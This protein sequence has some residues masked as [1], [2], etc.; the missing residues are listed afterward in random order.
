M[1]VADLF[2]PLLK[3]SQ[4]QYVVEALDTELRSIFNQHIEAPLS[5]AEQMIISTAA[6]KLRAWA[7]VRLQTATI[8]PQQGK[9]SVDSLKKIISNPQA[10]A[11]QLLHNAMIGSWT[12]KAW[13][14]GIPEVNTQA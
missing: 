6:L 5:K 1:F 4:C 7:L 2:D 11:K 3:E 10:V 13:G 8:E 14:D 9:I 12:K